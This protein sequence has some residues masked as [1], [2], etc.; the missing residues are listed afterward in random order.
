MKYGNFTVESPKFHWRYFSLNFLDFFDIAGSLNIISIL[1]GKPPAIMS[2]SFSYNIFKQM[3]SLTVV[4]ITL[5]QIS[6]VAEMMTAR[7]NTDIKHI[8]SSCIRT[9]L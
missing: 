3:S 5:I 4:Y 2:N 9:K 6:C 7:F 8:F 1:E